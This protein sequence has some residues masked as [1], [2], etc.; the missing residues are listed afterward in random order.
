MIILKKLLNTANLLTIM[1]CMPAYLSAASLGQQSPLVTQE[2]IN[3]Y[4][5]NKKLDKND[6]DEFLIRNKITANSIVALLKDRKFILQKEMV[7][8]KNTQSPIG[9]WTAAIAGS[10]TSLIANIGY[11]TESKKTGQTISEAMNY[12]VLHSGAMNSLKRQLNTG[13]ITQAEYNDEVKDFYRYHG[14]EPIV[15]ESPFIFEYQLLLWGSV[16]MAPFIAYKLYGYYKHEYDKTKEIQLIDRV[17]EQIN[18]L[19][20]KTPQ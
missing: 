10:V 17:I 20:E 19:I 3:L 7:Q 14:Y 1:F 5:L 4:L 18:A 11:N 9:Y 15:Y 6:F 8:F 12:H 2:V 13:W 16:I